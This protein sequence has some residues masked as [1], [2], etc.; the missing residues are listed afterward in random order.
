[1]G[2]ADAA[3][4]LDFGA[5]YFG[6]L[7]FC[8]KRVLIKAQ[9]PG[10]QNPDP[11]VQTAHYYN[12]NPS[13]S[14]LDITLPLPLPLTLTE[15]GEG[16]YEIQNTEV[17]EGDSRFLQAQGSYSAAVSVEDSNTLTLLAIHAIP[18]N[19]FLGVLK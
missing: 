19:V 5:L 2:L 8:C 6:A 11:L 9:S 7:Y 4:E 16:V 14:K 3:Q 1:M 12:S 15:V 13:P 18:E 17:S 10:V